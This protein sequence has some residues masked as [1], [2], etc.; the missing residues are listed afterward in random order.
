MK[1][2]FFSTVCAK[3]SLPLLLL[4]MAACSSNEETIYEGYGMI[5]KESGNTFSIILDNGV[6]LHPSEGITT[7]NSL[8]DSTRVRS[9]F[10]ILKENESY[11]YVNLMALDT[12][13]TL[14]VI[15]YDNNILNNMGDAP[16]SITNAWIAYGFLNFEFLFVDNQ[17]QHKFSLMQYPSTKDKLIFELRHN[18]YNDE[19]YQTNMQVISF[20]LQS[21]LK[22]A[23]KPAKIIIKYNRTDNMSDDIELTYR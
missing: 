15:P 22:E 2:L 11:S 7:L 4:A 8:Q 9:T 10:S 21:I 19:A 20:R 18:D 6:R 1:T 13:L 3:L 12:I 14:P 17:K 5:K 16:I 23:E